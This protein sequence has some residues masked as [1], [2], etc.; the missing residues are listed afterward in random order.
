MDTNVVVLAWLP[1]A[2]T[3]PPKRIIPV[4]YV[5]PPL[6]PSPSIRKRKCLPRVPTVELESQSRV[7]G[8]MVAVQ[9]PLLGALRG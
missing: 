5:C 4:G 3:R 6:S 7:P 8:R 1:A 2:Y 9:S